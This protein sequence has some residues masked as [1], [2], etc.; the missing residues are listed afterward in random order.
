MVPTGGRACKTRPKR[1]SDGKEVSRG[2]GRPGRVQV[3]QVEDSDKGWE[4][5]N[6]ARGWSPRMWM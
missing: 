1:E 3:V 4:K 2:M 5:T 6:G